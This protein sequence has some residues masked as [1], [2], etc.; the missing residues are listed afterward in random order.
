[1]TGFALGVVIV[2]WTVVIIFIAVLID[3]ELYYAGVYTRISN[4]INSKR[5]Q[6]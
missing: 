2:V 4:W 1:M 3:V 6:Q 5:K